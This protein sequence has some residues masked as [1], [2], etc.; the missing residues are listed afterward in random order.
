MII[1]Y[2]IEIYFVIVRNCS[3]W[4]ITLFVREEV[5]DI[6]FAPLSLK[7]LIFSTW[8]NPSVKQKFSPSSNFSFEHTEL[9][10]RMFHPSSA[11]IVLKIQVK[12]SK[13]ACFGYFHDFAILSLQCL[14]IYE[15]W[16]THH[17]D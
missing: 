1:R 10:L 17:D 3:F 16:I 2:T 15:F 6:R 11:L 9:S 5:R 14:L 7:D 8:A 12:W 13:E 4:I